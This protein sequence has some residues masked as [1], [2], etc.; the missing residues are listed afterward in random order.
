MRHSL[1]AITFCFVSSMPQAGQ[2]QESRLAL[3]SWLAGCWVPESGE[4]GSGEHWLPPA[5]GTMLGV[6][7]TV[8]GGRTVEYEF[9][10][11]RDN[12]EGKLVYIALPSGQKETT[13]VASSVTG[14]S[15]VFENPQHDFPQRVIYK[16]LPGNRLSA[17]I[18][19][20]RD[21]T[22]SGIDF[23]MKGVQC[24]WLASK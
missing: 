21:G 8:K 12:V 11:I 7:R 10:Q 22:L 17:R 14:D 16:A 24:E 1:I 15:A 2:A 18:E 13:F 9:L 5:G 19:G 3:L 23:P 20:V 6:A 4:P